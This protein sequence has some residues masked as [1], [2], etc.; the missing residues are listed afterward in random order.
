[1]HPGSLNS[2]GICPPPF[3]RKTSGTPHASPG[4]AIRDSRRPGKSRGAGAEREKEKKR[5]ILPFTPSGGPPRLPPPPRP[6][7]AAERPPP[8]RCSS[9]RCFPVDGGAGSPPP[10]APPASGAPSVGTYL[11]GKFPKFWR[12]WNGGWGRVDRD[13]GGEN[14]SRG[15]GDD[16][17]CKTVLWLHL[18]LFWASLKNLCEK[19][20]KK[21]CGKKKKKNL[22]KNLLREESVKCWLEERAQVFVYPLLRK[23]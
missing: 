16:T 6:G 8:S 2:S 22:V 21:L 18:A 10:P 5:G 23:V 3:P 7:F 4:I 1:M 12:G 19:S 20:L 9:L 15:S 13:H 17:W 14:P 11:L